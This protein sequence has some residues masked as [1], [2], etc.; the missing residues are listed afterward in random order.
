[1]NEYFTINTHEKNL[2]DERPREF[3]ASKRYHCIRTINTITKQTGI[4]PKWKSHL[5][6]K[7]FFNVFWTFLRRII[8][9]G[10][11]QKKIKNRNQ[12]SSLPPNVLFPLWN[13]TVVVRIQRHSPLSEKI[14][15][16]A[17]KKLIFLVNVNRE[18]PCIIA[19]NWRWGFISPSANL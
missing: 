16:T 15:P 8:M 14:L 11:A 10:H 1:M 4:E 2:F 9:C 3:F 7:H 18:R 5:M 6:V 12:K 19:Y 13:F 17:H